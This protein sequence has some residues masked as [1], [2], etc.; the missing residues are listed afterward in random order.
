MRIIAIDPGY[1]RVGVAIVQKNPRERE[2]L[3]YSD[4]IQTDA[5]ALFEERLRTIGEAVTRVI[6]DYD[7]DALAIEKIFFE[8]NQKTAMHVAEARGVMRYVAVQHKLPVYEYTPLEV[9]KAVTGNGH[10]SKEQIMKML[11]HL[12]HIDK[13]IEFDDEHDAIAI[14]LTCLAHLPVITPPK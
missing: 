10:A 2:N 6:V 14:G 13:K 9:K 8:K 5:R 11:P 1:D 4:C 12:V 7:P 3:L